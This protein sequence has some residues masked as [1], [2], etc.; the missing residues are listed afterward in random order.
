MQSL[1]FILLH[2]VKKVKKLIAQPHICTEIEWDKCK[3][4][5]NIQ[6]I[7]ND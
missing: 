4:R 7:H 2:I 1:T 6:S 3:N 5:N